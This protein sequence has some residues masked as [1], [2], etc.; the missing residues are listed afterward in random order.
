MPFSPIEHPAQTLRRDIDATPAGHNEYALVALAELVAEF[1]ERDRLARQEPGCGG[2]VE[3]GGMIMARH[4]LKL[5][6]R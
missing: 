4:A 2:I 6:G 5:L 3:T 1:D